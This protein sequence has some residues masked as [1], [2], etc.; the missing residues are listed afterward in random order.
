M[1]R[2]FIVCSGLGHVRRG[3]ESFTQECFDTLSLEPQLDITLFKGGGKSTNKSITL[4]NL[5]RVDRA[6]DQFAKLI[7]TSGYYL[8]QI[9]F[10][11]SLLPYIQRHQP[12]VIYFSDINIGNILWHWRRF[13]KQR[14]KLLLSNGGPVFPESFYRWDHIQQV[15]PQHFELAVKAGISTDKQSLVPYGIHMSPKLQP[16]TS[17]QRQ[18]SRIKLRLPTQRNLILC[19]AAINKS[20]KRLDYLIHEVANLPEPR[21]YLLV[22]GQQDSESSE[23]LHL[24]NQLLGNDGFQTREVPQEEVANYYKISD[25][26]VLPSLREGLPRVLIEAMSYGLPCLAHDYEVSRFILGEEGYFGD[27]SQKGALTNLINSLLDSMSSATEKPDRLLKYFARHTAVYDRFSWEV[28][29]SEYIAL[30]K[31]SVST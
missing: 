20:H 25:F 17:E 10:T 5:S 16:L 28:L 2:I 24:G 13:T 31:K 27:F 15:A 22:L 7:G 14:Y 23:I 1:R 12:N 26:F 8:E 9:S 19:I 4:W 18:A 3:Y 11:I 6:V 30:V 21:P 29:K